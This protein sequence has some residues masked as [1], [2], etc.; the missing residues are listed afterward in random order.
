MSGVCYVLSTASAAFSHLYTVY[1]MFVAGWRHALWSEW[2]FIIIIIIITVYY[3]AS[4]CE[5]I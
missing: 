3:V 5:A 2:P 1:C 4:D